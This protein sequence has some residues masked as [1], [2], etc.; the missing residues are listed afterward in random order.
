MTAKNRHRTSEKSA[1]SSQDDASKKTP[2]S[3][4]GSGTGGPGPQGSRSG[5]CL[6]LFANTVFYVALIGTAGFAAFYLQRVAEEMRQTT[7]WREESAR[8]S[9]VVGSK[10]DSVV[11]QVGRRMTRINGEK[12]CVGRSP[13]TPSW[14]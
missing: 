10:V 4:G 7:A 13:Q 6:G 14:M 8:Q 3:T 5:S 1:A 9:A 12:L 11:T 2:A